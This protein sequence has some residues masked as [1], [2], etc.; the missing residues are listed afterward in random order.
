MHAVGDLLKGARESKALSQRQLS[1]RSGISESMISRVERGSRS[2]SFELAGQLFAAM[3]WQLHL[4]LEP[5]DADI[6]RLIEAAARQPLVERLRTARGD[7]ASMIGALAGA[8]LTC[9]IEGTAA[10]LLQGAPVPVE[11]VE[12]AV[13]RTELDKLATMLASNFAKRWDPRWQGWGYINADP[14]EEG[15]L[16]WQVSW[17]GELHACLVDELPPFVTIELD[18]AACR[19]RPLI[20]LEVE[21]PA[22]ARML[23]RVRARLATAE[24]NR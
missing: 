10:A 14:R 5:L 9:V 4:E 1:Q 21:D 3:G 11:V 7:L 18:G 6:D 19:V 2:P 15:P 23:A 12:I 8:G 24:L 20:D 13:P 17:F 22:T 16:R